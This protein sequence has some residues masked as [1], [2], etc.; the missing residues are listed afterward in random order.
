MRAN[1]IT[2]R[3]SILEKL[4]IPKDCDVHIANVDI[5][6][7][8]DSILVKLVGNTEKLDKLGDGSWVPRKSYEEWQDLNEG[9]FDDNS[10]NI[11]RKQVSN[12]SHHKRKS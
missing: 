10:S 3:R 6:K 11:N 7:E 8:T 2:L 12:K 9:G 1:I 4:L 5:E